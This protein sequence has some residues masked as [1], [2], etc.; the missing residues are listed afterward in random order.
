MDT[1]ASTPSA[2]AV[3][4]YVAHGICDNREHVCSG[5]RT[6]VG[7]YGALCRV[8]NVVARC[9]CQ[10]CMLSMAAISDVSLSAVLC[11]TALM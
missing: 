10:R 2:I 9:D 3:P 7:R 5:L 1:Y 8:G 11:Q 4:W 6:S